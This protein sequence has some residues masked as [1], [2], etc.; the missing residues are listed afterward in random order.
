M[1]PSPRRLYADHPADCADP[2]VS[3][4]TAA[5]P[6]FTTDPTPSAVTV[7][8]LQP[9][10][11]GLVFPAHDGAILAQGCDD[12]PIVWRQG[13]HL[14]RRRVAWRATQ[15]AVMVLTSHQSV[16]L[17]DA[18]ESRTPAVQPAPAEAPCWSLRTRGDYHHQPLQVFRAVAS[19]LSPTRQL[20]ADA[21]SW[22]RPTRRCGQ[23]R[24][25]PETETSWA[26]TYQVL[27]LLPWPVRQSVCARAVVPQIF[28]A[29]LTRHPC[30]DGC[31]FYHLD[32]LRLNAAQAIV[33]HA[34]YHEDLP[35]W[36]VQVWHYLLRPH[37]AGLSTAVHPYWHGSIYPRP[38]AAVFGQSPSAQ[39]RDEAGGCKG[40][41]SAVTV[42]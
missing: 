35:V 23:D 16:E 13:E 9:A 21:H 28:E 4:P 33:V 10:H 38:A 20:V 39:G 36:T 17:L 7:C 42:G 29:T 24:Q 32:V 18:K 34:T 27:G 31:E 12:D 1:L 30:P 8:A 41:G 14:F 5:L 25:I 11:L 37:P 19:P 2:W 15:D 40:E 3:P 22:H 6:L 26:R